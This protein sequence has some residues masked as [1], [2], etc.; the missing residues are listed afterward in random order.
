MSGFGADPTGSAPGDGSYC[1]PD[2]R[3]LPAWD[4]HLVCRFELPEREDYWPDRIPAPPSGMA[5][6]PEESGFRDA[7]RSDL[8][9]DPGQLFYPQ[10]SESQGL[11]GP[12]QPATAKTVLG[13]PF[14]A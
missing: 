3:L 4:H 1:H 12:A 11:A 9:L 2:P 7:G 6:L 14:P 8:A 10:T 5:S 13:Q